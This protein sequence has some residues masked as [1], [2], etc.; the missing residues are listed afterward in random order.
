MENYKRFYIY[1]NLIIRK[2]TVG[3]KKDTDRKAYLVN[4]EMDD[5]TY[6]YGRFENLDEALEYY[7]SIFRKLPKF[8]DYLVPEQMKLF[9]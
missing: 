5:G 9:S 1:K 8:F 4:V 3:V 7:Y 2:A 6:R